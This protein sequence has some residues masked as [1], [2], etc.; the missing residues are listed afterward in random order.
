MIIANG[1][2]IVLLPPVD[3]LEV[4]YGFEGYLIHHEKETWKVLH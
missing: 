4:Y 1:F 2:A 3:I